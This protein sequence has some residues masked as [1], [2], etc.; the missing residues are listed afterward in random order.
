MQKVRNFV[1]SIIFSITIVMVKVQV[2]KKLH[3]DLKQSNI[4]KSL[5]Q[6]NLQQLWWNGCHN[7]IIPLI[8][9]QKFVLRKKIKLQYHFWILICTAIRSN[10]ELINSNCYSL[11]PKVRVTFFW[12]QSCWV[13][14]WITRTSKIFFPLRQYVNGIYIRRSKDV[15]DVFFLCLRG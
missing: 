5:Q 6:T 2:L 10:H 1:N 15:Q 8:P 12:L 3:D 9:G 13:T 4:Q 14:G 7:P 11:N